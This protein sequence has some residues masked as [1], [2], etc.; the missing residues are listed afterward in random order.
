MLSAAATGATAVAAGITAAEA[1]HILFE[2]LH[3]LLLIEESLHNA[4][5]GGSFIVHFAQKQYQK[6]QDEKHPN[7]EIVRNA[8][9]RYDFKITDNADKAILKIKKEAEKYLTDLNDRVSDLEKALTSFIEIETALTNLVSVLTSN[10]YRTLLSYV[11]RIKGYFQIFENNFTKFIDSLVLPPRQTLYIA[12]LLCEKEPKAPSVITRYNNRLKS[13][14]GCIEQLKKKEQAIAAQ[15]Y[16]SFSAIYLRPATNSSTVSV[17]R[18]VRPNDPLQQIIQLCMNYPDQISQRMHAF[19]PNNP[20]LATTCTDIL[21]LFIT[22]QQAYKAKLTNPFET[23][24]DWAPLLTEAKQRVV[25]QRIFLHT[26]DVHAAKEDEKLLMAHIFLPKAISE[27]E[28]EQIEV[29]QQAHKMACSLRNWQIEKCIQLIRL[30]S[31]IIEIVWLPDKDY[32]EQQLEELR[33]RLEGL[34]PEEQRP[35]ERQLEELRRELKDRHLLIEWLR[36]NERKQSL[37]ELYKEILVLPC[38]F[39][40]DNIKS[41]LEK[42]LLSDELIQEHRGS[43][44]G[45]IWKKND[46]LI[47][48]PKS[49]TTNVGSKHRT[50]DPR[51]KSLPISLEMW[52][53]SKDVVADLKRLQKAL[54]GSQSRYTE[55]INAFPRKQTTASE[56]HENQ[57]HQASVARIKQAQRRIC[58]EISSP[59]STISLFHYLY[60]TKT[61]N[62]A[63]K[64]Q[65]VPTLDDLSYVIYRGVD[66][67]GVCDWKENTKT[68]SRSKQ[69]THYFYPDKK[70]DDSRKKAW[71]YACTECQID[72]VPLFFHLFTDRFLVSTNTPNPAPTSSLVAI[73]N[74]LSIQA[75][76]K[77]SKK[78]LSII[79]N[80]KALRSVPPKMVKKL[81]IIFTDLLDYYLSALARMEPEYYNELPLI[82]RWGCSFRNGIRSNLK[83]EQGQPEVGQERLDSVRIYI[84]DL[85]TLLSEEDVESIS[86]VLDDLEENYKNMS[87]KATL[88]RSSVLY[89]IM[90]RFVTGPLIDIKKLKENDLGSASGSGLTAQRTETPTTTDESR[91][92]ERTEARG[93]ETEARG[94]E[95]ETQEQTTEAEK[96]RLHE[97]LLAKKG[98]PPTS[99]ATVAASPAAFFPATTTPRASNTEAANLN[100]PGCSNAS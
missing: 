74:S 64:E 73:N 17:F 18:R 5:K 16:Q 62:K 67:N 76:V 22:I 38:C 87:K 75:I 98:R 23:K 53:L 55:I 72:R 69:L 29:D 32:E 4:H 86:N 46:T 65:Q 25:G 84:G 14:E 36:T 82:K 89:K 26:M 68:S 27:Y 100:L 58:N 77:D 92:T 59:S 47:Q 40:E 13:I 94:Q 79:T 6:R 21:K 81:E 90:E 61:I 31:T 12:D 20:V 99:Q 83:V 45:A 78:T 48:L 63:D 95:T 15:V 71:F 30:L 57:A 34:Q 1:I 3:R 96:K 91:E 97:V 24:P 54:E 85:C 66:P 8:K 42:S 33:Q 7:Q 70:K 9:T 10:D 60:Q 41:A 44:W 39:S 37:I 80:S 50:D 28:M 2:Y 56:V 43:R 49:F 19:L 35:V 93:Q 11:G 51:Q 88:G 52:Q